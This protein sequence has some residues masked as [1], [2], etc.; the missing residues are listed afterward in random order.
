MALHN[1][2]KNSGYLVF[3]EVGFNLSNEQNVNT[4]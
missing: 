1:L 3:C 2:M 4:L